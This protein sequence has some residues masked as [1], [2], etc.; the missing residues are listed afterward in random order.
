MTEFELEFFEDYTRGVFGA[1]LVLEPA[2]D[3][4]FIAFSKNEVIDWKLSSEEERIVVG[5]LLI[6]EQRI[7][8]KAVGKD[9]EE[10]NTFVKAETI[11]RLQQNFFKNDYHHNSTIEH[12]GN[13]IEDVFFFESWLVLNSK[14]DKSNELGFNVPQGTWMVAMKINNDDIWNNYVKTGEVKGLSIDAMLSPKK[15]I[16]NKLNNMNKNTI[17]ELAKIAFNSEL[18]KIKFS[19][20]KISEEL[21]VFAEKL[22]L[23]EIVTDKDGNLLIDSEFIFDG[24]KYSTDSTGAIKEI[25]K[26]EVLEKEDIEMAEELSTLETDK[27]TIYFVGPMLT[28][29]G[30]VFLDDQKTPLEVREY[31]LTESEL[32]LVVEEAGIVADLIEKKTEEGET[33]E[34]A[35][36]LEIELQ[37][38]LDEKEALVLEL[39]DKIAKLEE[40]NGKLQE[41]L[42]LKEN[43]VVA[44]SKE[45]PAS[46]GIVD[47]L[48]M[49]YSLNKEESRLDALARIANQK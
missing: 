49:N 22:E 37:A 17:A 8:R 1:S 35:S 23:D 41:Q 30:E 48:V 15:I 11:K 10:G 16:N 26:I 34:M 20:F 13:M 33:T 28:K 5:P 3:E 25:E 46:S 12:D 27:G 14:N 38:K 29:G 47:K 45:T 6:P 24:H 32:T 31:I 2:T 4:E 42:V 18:E 36:E 7:Y 43:E 44:L 9:K 40:E 21:S 19:E 39:E